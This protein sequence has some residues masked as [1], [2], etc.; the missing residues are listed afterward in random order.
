MGMGEEK[1]DI[2]EEIA[3]KILT[4]LLVV[5]GVYAVFQ[6]AV[7]GIF[8]LIMGGND[9]NGIYVLFYG[10]IVVLLVIFLLGAGSGWALW[11]R[12]RAPAAEG[13]PSTFS[14]GVSIGLLVV[15]LAAVYILGS[16]LRGFSR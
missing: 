4:A 3:G 6:L 11:R 16:F 7:R 2:G 10:G 1:R 15:V 8:S 13:K 14:R 12:S 9:N 5:A